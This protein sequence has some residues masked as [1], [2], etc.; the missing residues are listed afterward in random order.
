MRRK[1]PDITMTL[2]EEAS[3]SY[4]VTTACRVLAVP[5]SWYYRQKVAGSQVQENRESRPRPQQALSVAEKA[6]VRTVL[7]SERFAD[8]SPREVYATLLDEGRYL[9]HWR[10][11]YRVLAEHEEVRERRNQRQH[12]QHD[13]PQLLASRPNELW[14]WDI[15]LLKGQTR[16][17]FYYLYVILDVYSRF[18]VGWMVA[19]G[20]SSELAEI[21]IAAT[22]DKQKIRRDQLT[23]HADRGSAM[24]AQT[25][26]Q[27]LA[28]L[29]VTK[30]HSRPYTP[31]DNP[32]SEAQFK[33]MKYRPN[34]PDRFESL[35]Q[36]RSWARAFFPWYNY[37][38]HHTGLGL[39]TPA[40]VHYEHVDEVRAK[41]QCVLDDA[42]AAHPERFVKGRP[43]APNAPDQVWIN[44]PQ[45][46]TAARSAPMET[47]PVAEVVL[48]V[49]PAISNNGELL[50]VGE[51]TLWPSS[52]E[53]SSLF[54]NDELFQNA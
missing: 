49:G 36:A 6:E 20:E 4:G 46:T 14:S 33:T 16:R 51:E 22:C 37:E 1:Q 48:T 17:L 5:R 21:L 2:L 50:A 25:L 23:L 43:T 12:P 53:K 3:L 18:V 35:D 34:Y 42:Y 31:D 26:A 52:E 45:P 13:K 7:N 54:S 19:Q 32:Y 40:V 28:D 38:H 47:R 44:S 15:T 8:E 24:R 9:C 10:T 39:M 27:M 29:G 41:R 11:M 30:T